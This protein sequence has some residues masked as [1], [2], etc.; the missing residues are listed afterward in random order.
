MWTVRLTTPPDPGKPLPATPRGPTRV[1][2]TPN[3]DCD[4]GAG[5]GV[6]RDL[7]FTSAN[8]NVAQQVQITVTQDPFVELLHECV[9]QPTVLG[10]D[11]VYADLSNPPVFSGTPPTIELDIQDY[12]P[13][14]GITDDPP[15]VDITTSSLDVDEGAGT[16]DTISVVL[17]R[18][19][20]RR[21]GARRGRRRRRPEDRR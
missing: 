15:F 5:P 19:P 14:N 16:I 20:G 11:P 18:A 2:F 12:D 9:V 21:A 4:V 10:D 6:A 7:T 3:E 17:R 8:W 1:R 13:P